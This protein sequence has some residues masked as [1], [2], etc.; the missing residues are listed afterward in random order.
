VKSFIA[1]GDPSAP[2]SGVNNQLNGTWG[3]R[4]AT[5]YASNGFVFSVSGGFS[6]GGVTVAN[7]DGGLA[8]IPATFA[9]GT[10]NTIVWVERFDVF[11]N[12]SAN[13][14]HSWSTDDQGSSVLAPGIFT[15][16]LPTFGIPYAQ[17]AGDRPNAFSASGIQVGLGDGSV[18]LVNSGISQ[19][20]WQNALFPAD[21]NVL[22][23]DW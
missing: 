1:P 3:N 22:G 21:G 6:S 10:S 18:R 23:S 9:D 8:R 13:L 5:S 2:G 19:Q 7:G 14:S 16:T 20:T 12:S 4:A 17:V 11:G 15:Y